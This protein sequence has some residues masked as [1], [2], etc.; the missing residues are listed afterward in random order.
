MYAYIYGY[1]RVYIRICTRIYTYMYAYIQF[2][3]NNHEL[4]NCFSLLQK[5]KG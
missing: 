4:L 2:L 1:V 3:L 5:S